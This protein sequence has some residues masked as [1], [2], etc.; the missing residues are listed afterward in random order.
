MSTQATPTP[1]DQLSMTARDVMQTS[2]LSIVPDAPL[3]SIQQLFF[4]EQIHGAPVIDDTGRLVGIVTSMDLVRCATEERS[5]RE[6][7][8][9]TGEYLAELLDLDAGGGKHVA[10][11]VGAT[12]GARTAADVMTRDPVSVAPEARLP[13]IARCLTQFGIHRVPVIDDAGELCG[14]ISSA[15]LVAAIASSG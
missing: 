12:F 4:D 2:V 5:D 9:A 8:L 1:I 13:E 11:E 3:A 7:S 15:D 6:P 10:V 14:I